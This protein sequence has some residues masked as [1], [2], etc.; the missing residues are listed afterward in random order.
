[1]TRNRFNQAKNQSGNSLLGLTST[2]NLTLSKARGL[3][4]EDNDNIDMKDT[5]KITNV[6]P[7]LDEK[8]VVNKEYCDNSLL[9]SSNKIEILSRNITELRKGDFDKVT[10]KTLQLNET[11]VNENLIKEFIKSANEVTNVVNFCNKVAAD[12]ISKYNQLKQEIDNNKFNQNVTNIHLDDM[13]T[14]GLR[15]MK[16]YNKSLRGVIVIYIISILLRSKLLDNKEKDRLEMHYGFKQEDITKEIESFSLMKMT[17]LR[18]SFTDPTAPI[19][20]LL[21]PDLS[22]VSERLMREAAAVNEQQINEKIQANNKFNNNINIIKDIRNYYETETNNYKKKLSRYKNYINVAEITEILLSSIATTATT[23]SVALTGIGL[24]CS[25]PTAFA[26]ATV[27][28]SLSKTINTKIRNKIIKYSQMYILAKQLS[29]KFNKLY[30]KSMNDNKIDNDEY[31]EL[32]KVY[33]D[34]KKNKKN[35]LSVFLN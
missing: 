9:S 3:F 16:E 24:P 35:K 10:T 26:T 32:V 1:M 21:Y 17:N 22:S 30:T 31:N 34:Y 25:I 12:T 13:F 15:E 27:C 11:Q 2:N 6:H 5:Y 14:N 18:S 28:G 4:L 7:P 29:D 19:E 33:E 23:T 20:S 8:D